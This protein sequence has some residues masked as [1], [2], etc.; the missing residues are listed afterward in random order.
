MA[1]RV[2]PESALLMLHWQNSVCDP[3]GVWGMNLFPQIEKNN[4][5]KNAQQ[6]GRNRHRELRCALVL[7][8]EG[9][10]DSCQQPW[11]RCPGLIAVAASGLHTFV[12]VR[13]RAL[14]AAEQ[15]VS[16]YGQA[17]WQPVAELTCHA[18][19]RRDQLRELASA[20]AVAPA[21]LDDPR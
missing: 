21:L 5:I 4:A 2:S 9:E 19:K 8:G 14:A 16:E 1:K 18:P 13:A 17:V 11:Q 10:Q 7:D 6:V 15:A 3:R 12:P 20:D